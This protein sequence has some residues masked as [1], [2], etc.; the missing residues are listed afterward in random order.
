METEAWRG[1]VSCS[2]PYSWKL[3]ERGFEPRQAGSVLFTISHH[4]ISKTRTK[5]YY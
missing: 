3:A 5:K 4:A 2:R 1:K